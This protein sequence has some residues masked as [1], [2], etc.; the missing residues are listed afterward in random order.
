[1]ETS[2]ID[3]E[4]LEHFKKLI[5]SKATIEPQHTNV[6]SRLSEKFVLAKVQ[7]F[8]A[9]TIEAFNQLISNDLEKIQIAALLTIEPNKVDNI[10]QVMVDDFLIYSTHAIKYLTTTIRYDF[11]EGTV[12]G[13]GEKFQETFKKCGLEAVVNMFQQSPRRAL[14]WATN[15]W[16]STIIAENY[17]L[18]LMNKSE[19][20]SSR[21]KSLQDSGIDI[22]ID[23]IKKCTIYF[24]ELKSLK[25]FNDFS[26]ECNRL[27]EFAI[28]ETHSLFAKFQIDLSLNLTKKLTYDYNTA[29]LII[30]E[31]KEPYTGI[32][33][34][35][36]LVVQFLFLNKEKN[37]SG[38][39][40]KD[41]NNIEGLSKT[42]S[43]VQD[44]FQD[45]NEKKLR[46]DVVKSVHGTKRYKF[47][48]G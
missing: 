45:N 24:D 32:G 38:F 21:K 8:N 17:C 14:S 1:M 35:A 25:F 34:D 3:N 4:K 28:K 19:I 37:T 5:L 10:S 46:T 27:Q 41:F 42:Y 26:R 18:Y 16:L 22:D 13:F 44:I 36:F 15:S 11:E 48:I 47:Q 7:N 6:Y 9:I 2:K 39:G 30:P 23:L 29:R 40:L 33:H 31:I 20:I 43:K 12:N